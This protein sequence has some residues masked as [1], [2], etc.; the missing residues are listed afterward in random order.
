MKPLLTLVLLVPL[1]AATAGELTV[2]VPLDPSSILTEATGP[3]TRVTGE[4][5]SLTG[6]VG[7]PCLPEMTARFALPTGC[8]ATGM[9]I[10]ETSWSTLRSPC[11]VLPA[12]PAVPLSVETEIVPVTPDPAI[13]SSTESFPAVPARFAG[14]SVISG[15]PV[16]YAQV[17]PVRW[18]PTSKELEVLTSLT[19]NLTYEPSQEASTVLRRS[20]QSEQRAMQTVR[21][22]VVNPDGVS[23]SGAT[24]VESRDLEYGEYVIVT[25][26]TYQTQA[27]ELADW[28]TLKGVPT[29][30]YTTTW[31]QTQYSCY[32]LQQE[33]RAFLTDCITEGTEY[34]LIYG[35]DNMIAGRD[36][37]I[38][39]SSYTEY[40]PVDLYWSDIND[41][42]PGADRWDSNGNHVWGEYGADA[43]D[44]H[45]DLWT[46][47]ASVNSV[48]EA[49]I[50]NDKVFIYEGIQSTDYFTTAPREMR[51]GYTTELLWGSPYWCYGSAGAE[52]ISALVPSSAW[53]EEKC[54]DSGGLNS[55]TITQAML[56][57]RPHQVYHASHGSATSFSLPGGSYGTGHFMALT[58]I[59]SGGLPAIWNSISCLIGHLDGYECMGDA[60]LASPNGGGFGAF[61][62][63]YGWGSP[64][65][66]GYG[67]SEVLCKYFY[68]EMWN[69]DQHQLG[70]A[71]AMGNDD[72]CPPSEAVK[73]WCVK[74]Y[75]LFGDPELPMWYNDESSPLA[76]S[77]PATVYG[78]GAVTVTVTA[79]GSPVNG[80][81]VCIKK[82]DWQT[83][84][85]YE[86]GTTNASGTVDLFADPT[87]TGT[88]TIVVT[89]RDHVP[90][91]GTI[92]V[93]A[94]GIGEGPES[95]YVNSV[96][97]VFPS[98]AMA[99]V[100]VPFSVATGG[101]ARV[102]VYDL[103]GRVVATLTDGEIAAGQH[104]LVWDLT[105][106]GGNTVPS[107][108]YHVM[109]STPEWSGVTG[110]VVSR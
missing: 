43:V 1:V 110:L 79:G 89:A 8:A 91:Q 7:A 100:T 72:M 26:P 63:R 42:A 23:A 33:I 57:A 85:V 54:Y 59:S 78:S 27:Q 70:V 88:M 15:I 24:I 82:G 28:K 17:F 37:K 22:S 76:A 96:G 16:A 35:D 51:I 13:Y 64:S 94:T 38:S 20:L 11:V 40:P 108:L 92:N 6:M 55:V 3:Y 53:E 75:N 104:S 69:M 84:E 30:V 86:V 98:P 73:D 32:D 25:H 49:L 45:P 97:S 61:N 9:E 52:L 103:T 101:T 68:L 58:N 109:V 60:W 106:S 18:N 48:A 21:N 77:Y 2:N 29:N 99:S 74:E 71:H 31:I 19:V 46:G 93:D 105:G 39:Y 41:T 34:V 80:A 95:V 87:S 102:D 12:A 14:S 66:P 50:F 10:V 90:L 83:G 107:G 56:N 5:M 62:A 44:Y 47:R 67:V 65:N 4:N 36:A 81:R